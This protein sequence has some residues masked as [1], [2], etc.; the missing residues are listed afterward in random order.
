MSSHQH[1]SGAGKRHKLEG[2]RN[3]YLSYIISILLTILAFAAVMYGGLDRSFLIIFLVGLGIVQA[4]FQLAYWMHMKD[5]GHMLPIV[6]LLFGFFIAL[7]G[8]AAAVFWM[9]W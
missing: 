3:H 5:K 8:A 6:G 4:I 7:T 1:T 9:W 2:P